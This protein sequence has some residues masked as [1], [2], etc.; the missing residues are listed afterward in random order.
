MTL[1]VKTLV[2]YCHLIGNRVDYV[3]GAGGNISLKDD[4]GIMAIKASGTQLD[5]VSHSNGIAYVSYENYAKQL[6]SCQKESDY[7][8][9]NQQQTRS[10]LATERASMEVGFHAV[11]DTAVIHTHNVYA[12]ILLCSHEGSNIIKAEFPTATVLDYVTPGLELI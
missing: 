10:D 12:N 5:H 9:L 4:N 2:K 7:N 11:L 3:Q 6:L 1:N 8:L